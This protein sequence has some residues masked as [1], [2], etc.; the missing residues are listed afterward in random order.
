MV[1]VGG[2]LAWVAAS[3]GGVGGVLSKVVC[4]GRWRANVSGVGVTLDWVAC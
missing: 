3:V 4:L 2:M 1:D